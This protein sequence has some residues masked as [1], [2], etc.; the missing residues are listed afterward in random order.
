MYN[1]KFQAHWLSHSSISTYKNCPLAYYYSAVYKT[2]DKKKISTTSP[3]L[4]LGCAVHAPLEALAEVA[5][6][7]RKNTK[8]APQFFKTWEEFSGDKGGFDNP[9]QEETFKQRGI[10]ML[11]N[12]K[13]NIHHLEGESAFLLPDH[14]ELPWF[15]FSEKEN[16]ILSGK[17]DFLIKEKDGYYVIDFKTGNNVE[18]ETSLQLP[19]YRLLLNN[20]LGKSDFRAAYWYVAKDGAPV[21]KEMPSLEESRDLVMDIALKIRQARIDKV[22]ECPNGDMGCFA[23]RDYRKIIDGAATFVGLGTYGGKVYKINK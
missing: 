23:C 17:L 6:E 3:H 7:D 19:I 22:F 10:E 5:S 20:F 11:K 8:F 14:N 18:K 12:V 15:W 21:E 9:E 1:N 16:L 4:A 2:E 13:A